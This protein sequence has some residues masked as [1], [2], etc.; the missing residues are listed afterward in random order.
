MSVQRS[1]S[2]RPLCPKHYIAMVIDTNNS[3]RVVVNSSEATEPHLFESPADGCPQ[4]YSPSLGYFVV[5]RNKDH[6]HIT[7][8]SSVTIARNLTQVICGDHNRMFIE[9]FD[10]Q[11]NAH[12]FRCPQRDCQKAL[13]IPADG[14]PAYWLGEGFFK[15][16]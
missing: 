14:P 7:G 16:T 6:W 1:D 9:A 13:T 8:S 15:S 12:N 10:P 5:K 3:E 2:L 4:C 11:V